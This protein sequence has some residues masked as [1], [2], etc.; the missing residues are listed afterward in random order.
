[1]E[2]PDTDTGPVQYGSRRSSSFESI[3]QFEPSEGPSEKDPFQTPYRMNS[4][5][6]S[7][8]MSPSVVVSMMMLPSESVMASTASGT[9]LNWL[10]PTGR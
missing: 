8:V 4:V 3:S 10:Q 2:P 9:V 7:P 1:M 6:A 5:N